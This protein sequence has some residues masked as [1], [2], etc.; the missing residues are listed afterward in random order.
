MVTKKCTRLLVVF[1][2][3]VFAGFVSAEPTYQPIP[4][5]NGLLASGVADAHGPGGTGWVY[6][7]VWD[8]GNG[9]YY[10][11]YM[12]ENPAGT[13]FEPYIKHLE[14]VNLTGNE[15]IITGSSG[16]GDP[17]VSGPWTP[18]AWAPG[19]AG[20]LI[21]WTADLSA[22]GNAAA[23]YPGQVSWTSDPLFQ[24]A[25]KL[26][27]A[28]A[29]FKVMQGT[30]QTY[31]DGIIPAPQAPNLAKPRSPGYWKH[32]VVGKGNKKESLLQMLGFFN[33]IEP[34]S[35]VFSDDLSG[36]GSDDYNVAAP[37]ILNPADSSIMQAKAERQLFALWLNV[38]SNKM[39]YFDEMTFE[40]P[41]GAIVTKSA[42]D[43]INE[44]EGIINS[45]PTADQLEYAK[46]LAEILNHM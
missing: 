27:P 34:L 20:T 42:I 15:F 16:G 19:G 28:V 32:Q 39:S 23:V 18:N 24:F 26:P 35:T 4:D 33:T 9:W 30:P 2:I 41:N 38:A 10:Y 8:G 40:D 45:S 3:L 21:T 13:S 25:S 12:I 17:A 1:L 11:S 44:I 29:N 7:W 46:D 37:A 31:A 22:T 14:I 36:G 5:S 6:Y 43:V